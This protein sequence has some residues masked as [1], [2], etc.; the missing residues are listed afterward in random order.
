VPV[1][2]SLARRLGHQRWFARVVPVLVPLDR[3]VGRLTRGRVL[4]LGLI[5]SLL[6]TTTGRRSGRPRT[7][8]LLFVPDS[9]AFVVVGSNW[10]RAHHPA[11]ALN[12]LA[13]PAA[14]LTVAGRQI[15]VRATRITGADRDL[16]WRRLVAQWPAYETYL[17]RAGDRDLHIFRLEPLR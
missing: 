15:P 5:P 17:D 4:A 16:L 14:T 12:L 9:D 8:P 1:L 13:D 7:N 10:G 3:L 11:W 2:G 6:I